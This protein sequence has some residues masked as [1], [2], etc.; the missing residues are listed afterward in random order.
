MTGSAT[1]SGSNSSSSQVTYRDA[2]GR[3]AVGA[4]SYI[5]IE[6]RARSMMVQAI[7]TFPDDYAIV[8]VESVF[9]L[10]EKPN[11]QTF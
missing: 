4:F 6:T 9:T 1:T 5:H 10:P 11:T 8:K 2:S 3:L 7:H